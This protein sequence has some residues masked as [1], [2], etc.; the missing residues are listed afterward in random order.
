M[1]LYQPALQ[2][3]QNNDS[4]NNDSKSPL[5]RR[6]DTVGTIIAEV[7]L[8]VSKV[9]CAALGGPDLD[10]M[11][12]TSAKH[13]ESE[14]GGLFVAKVNVPGVPESRFNDV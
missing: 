1:V 12:I 10:W 5:P 8:P 14:S 7:K 3:Q 6:L 2:L 11:F 9:T 4:N 13:H